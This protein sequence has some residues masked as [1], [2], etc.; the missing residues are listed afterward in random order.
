MLQIPYLGT[1]LVVSRVPIQQV[2][3]SL[4]LASPQV[5]F[6]AVAGVGQPSEPKR[7]SGDPGVMAGLEA[8][9]AWA[10]VRDERSG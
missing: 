7:T 5:S 10:L 8:D 4:P 6:S 1:P 3:K 9:G 2:A